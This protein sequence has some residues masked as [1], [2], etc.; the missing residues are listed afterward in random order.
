MAQLV[1]CLVFSGMCPQFSKVLLIF[2]HFFSSV[3]RLDN[4]FGLFSK[5]PIL[6]SVSLNLLLSP[7]VNFSFQLLCFPLQNLHLIISVSSLI[8]S[9]FTAFFRHLFFI[10]N[11]CSI[12]NLT[13]ILY[14]MSVLHLILFLLL[15]TG[16]FKQYI[17]MRFSCLPKFYCCCLVIFL[18]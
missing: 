9:A 3:P 12:V 10:L 11:I 1:C 5:F 17:K 18:D 15:K 14:R 6:S 7:L 16:H 13:H 2:L 8:S 4:L